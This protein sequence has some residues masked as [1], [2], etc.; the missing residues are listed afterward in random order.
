M[1]V[2]FPPIVGPSARV[3][4]LGSLPGVVSLKR[5]EYYAQPQNTFWRI[6][7]ELFGFSPELPYAA[8]TDALIAHHVAVWDVCASAHRPGSLDSAIA[9]ESVQANDFASLYSRQ[10]G[11]RLICFNG[12]AA[13]HLY[14]R[15]VMPTLRADLREIPS[16]VLPSTSPAHASVPYKA[17][18]SAWE[19]VCMR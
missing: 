18:R 13:S 6:M 1:S 2:G 4:I 5:R 7:G 3:L 11:I 9:L 12:A 14:K 10:I 15:R 19:I 16:R 17:K 8:R